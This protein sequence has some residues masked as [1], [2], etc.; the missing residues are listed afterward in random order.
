MKQKTNLKCSVVHLHNKRIT[1]Y[2]VRVCTLN[3]KNARLRDRT[4]MPACSRIAYSQSPCERNRN[5]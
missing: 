1:L 2:T 4:R 3:S 5:H